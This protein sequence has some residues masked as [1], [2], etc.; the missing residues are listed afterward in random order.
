MCV[1]LIIKPQGGI[2]LMQHNH[3]IFDC[4]TTIIGGLLELA[5]KPVDFDNIDNL[6]N[7][8]ISIESISGLKLIEKY[9]LL[10]L[11][12]KSLGDKHKYDYKI[13]VLPIIVDVCITSITKATKEDPDQVQRAIKAAKITDMIKRIEDGNFHASGTFVSTFGYSDDSPYRI[14]DDE[15]IFDYGN[16]L[17]DLL[18][19]HNQSVKYNLKLS[20]R[21]DKTRKILNQF[22]DENSV[23]GDGSHRAVAALA[24][25]QFTR[26]TIT[27][28]V[29]KAPK[30]TAYEIFADCNNGQDKPSMEQQW[31]AR[32]QSGQLNQDQKWLRNVIR[33]ISNDQKSPLYERINMV[34]DSDKNTVIKYSKMHNLLSKYVQKHIVNMGGNEMIGAKIIKD[35]LRL[36]QN[37][38][39]D[40]VWCNNKHYLLTK[41]IGFEI[42]LSMFPLFFNKV[43]SKLAEKN[44]YEN[45]KELFEFVM[46]E[47]GD[48]IKFDIVG[49]EGQKLEFSL[50][51]ISGE[52]G[53][54]Q[55]SS[56]AGIKKIRDAIEKVV[57]PKIVKYKEERALNV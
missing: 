5:G 20:E 13:G 31:I 43:S 30:G 56:G 50:D 12:T 46:K 21:V 19:H 18:K 51:F 9:P 3:A 35:Y 29:D 2:Y 42:I 15:F 36:W 7:R 26:E 39:T 40:K 6:R 27:V 28:L 25:H 1:Y 49:N 32:E 16:L 54:G 22:R 45:L 48:Y 24:A 14:E 17:K 37:L 55:Y 47:D 11:N 41:S 33:D 52:K 53:I 38:Y 10:T 4:E 34:S 23:N 8:E 44:S 57:E